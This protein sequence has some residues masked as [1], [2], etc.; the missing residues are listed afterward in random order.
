MGL[1]CGTYG[2]TRNGCK[3]IVG[4][5]DVKEHLEDLE[6]EGRIILKCILR[7]EGGFV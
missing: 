7:K 6:V 5:Y 4:K 2:K 1:A 3:H